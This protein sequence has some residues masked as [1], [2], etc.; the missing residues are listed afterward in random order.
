MTIPYAIAW[1]CEQLP[2]AMPLRQELPSE[3]GLAIRLRQSA[4]EAIAALG[5]WAPYRS[6]YQMYTDAS[7]SGRIRGSARGLRVIGLAEAGTDNFLGW[8]VA[9]ARGSCAAELHGPWA[10][11]QAEAFALAWGA[12]VAL[13]L[14]SQSLG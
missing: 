7:A 12:L 2:W 5:T 11:T 9:R 10:S 4:A 8:L 3:S 13:Q 6:K 1:H 14:P